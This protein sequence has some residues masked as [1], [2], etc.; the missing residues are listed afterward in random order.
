VAPRWSLISL[1]KPRID[2][3]PAL[4]PMRRLIHHP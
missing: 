2:T 4:F 3:P 1:L